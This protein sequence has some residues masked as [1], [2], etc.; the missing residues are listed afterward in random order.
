VVEID[1]AIAE[2]SAYG[3]LQIKKGDLL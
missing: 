2:Q 1:V 3:V